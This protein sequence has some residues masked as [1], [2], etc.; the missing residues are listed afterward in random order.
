MAKMIDHSTVVPTKR[1]NGISNVNPGVLNQGQEVCHDSFSIGRELVV[2]N[3]FDRF[4]DLTFG[5]LN[6]SRARASEEFSVESSCL[7]SVVES[8]NGS[9]CV[10]ARTLVHGTKSVQNR[11]TRVMSFARSSVLKQGNHFD[12]ES[13]PI[14]NCMLGLPD[15][16][17]YVSV[18]EGI[19]K[20][21]AR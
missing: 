14:S 4:D 19:P 18:F 12:D 5:V 11:K 16:V 20:V 3:L 8:T 13:K 17:L 9:S 2:A 7:V 6:R 10:E 1:A 15:F 21:L